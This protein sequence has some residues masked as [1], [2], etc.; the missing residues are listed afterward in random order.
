MDVA[1]VNYLQDVAAQLKSRLHPA[2]M[3]KFQYTP[4][5]TV[6]PATVTSCEVL[7]SELR[8]GQHSW[9]LFSPVHIDKDGKC[10]YNQVTDYYDGIC[11]SHEVGGVILYVPYRSRHNMTFIRERRTYSSGV[12][13]PVIDSNTHGNGATAASSSRHHT[14]SRDQGL[15]NPQCSTISLRARRV[16]R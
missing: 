15:P 9:L 5:T 3:P 12:L 16:Q 2:R 14:V 4:S 10:R 13:D 11:C 8:S 6:A 1:K 7:R